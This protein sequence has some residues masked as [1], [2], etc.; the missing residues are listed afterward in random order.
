MYFA[1]Q[2]DWHD[3]HGGSESKFLAPVEARLVDLD[4]DGRADLV[5]SLRVG[6][7]YLTNGTPPSSP[8][9]KIAEVWLNTGAGW[10][11]NSALS[12]TIPEFGTLHVDNLWNVYPDVGDYV[13]SVFARVKL[14]RAE[15]HLADLD[16]DGRIDLLARHDDTSLYPVPSYF[17]PPPMGAWYFRDSGWAPAP[18]SLVPPQPFVA[19]VSDSYVPLY[20]DDTGMRV[21]DVNGDGLADLVKTAYEPDPDDLRIRAS[22]LLVESVWLNTGSA[23]CGPV[24]GCDT[25]RYL[26]PGGLSFTKAVEGLFLAYAPNALGFEDLNGDGLLDLL[27]S[28]ASIPNGR[29]AWLNDPAGG[30]SEG[31]RW[32]EDPRFAPPAGFE[33]L[34]S[35]LDVDG[36][37]P[38]YF[39]IPHDRGVALAD[40]DG[41]GTPDLVRSYGDGAGA[42]RAA[43]VSRSA[44][45]DLVASF[46]NGE[47]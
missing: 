18:S 42:I 27:L 25:A 8:G 33:H 7:T 47:G 20:H 45:P 16:G 37:P 21:A 2:R 34:E 19:S 41:N 43:Q 32:R 12:T 26:P 36:T 24:E 5:A 38:Y 4:G 30:T 13:Y 14:I 35:Q 28:D 15:T 9:V 3:G 44:L 6:A 23:W 1:T 46:D 17:G 39:M 29:R 10:E 40:V 22:A 31:A 11:R